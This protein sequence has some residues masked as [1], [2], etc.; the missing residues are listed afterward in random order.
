MAGKIIFHYSE[1]AVHN[2]LPGRAGRLRAVTSP[3]ILLFAFRG[4]T[5]R[6]I[7]PGVPS[8]GPVG[9]EFQA[10]PPAA[11]LPECETVSITAAAQLWQNQ[12]QSGSP[13]RTKISG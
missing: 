10:I 9:P 12:H 4:A 1:F 13:K 2:S 11:G 7:R 3:F 8:T 6:K 5:V